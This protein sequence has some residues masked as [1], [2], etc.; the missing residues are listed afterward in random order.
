MSVLLLFV[1]ICWSFSIL[2]KTLDTMDR[3]VN[4]LSCELYYKSQN[5]DIVCRIFSDG[6][7][8][9][10]LSNRA[11]ECMNACILCPYLTCGTFLDSSFYIGI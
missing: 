9:A 5:C 6:F 4:K 2:N 8:L 3:C 11:Q 10:S 1:C 7:D